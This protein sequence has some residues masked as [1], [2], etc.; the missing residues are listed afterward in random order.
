MFQAFF[1]TPLHKG[2]HTIGWDMITKAK[3]LGGL[4]IKKKKMRAMNIAMLINQAWRLWINPDSLLG[5]SF[6][7]QIFSTLDHTPPS[8]IVI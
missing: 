5:K 3:E 7:K 8:R 1:T 6:E 4:N 2:H